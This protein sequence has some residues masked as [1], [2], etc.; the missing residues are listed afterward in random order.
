MKRFVDSTGRVFWKGESWRVELSSGGAVPLLQEP[1]KD[2]KRSAYVFDLD[3]TLFDNTARKHLVPR[4]DD[5]LT[6]GGWSK[7]NEHCHLDEIIEKSKSL[8]LS[9]YGMGHEILYVTSRCIDG[10]RE[11][12]AMLEEHN[13]PVEVDTLIMRGID[14]NRD[15]PEVKLDLFNS[16]RTEYHI[17]GAYDDDETVISTLISAG[18][19]MIKV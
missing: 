4:G 13:L 12:Y 14:D 11:T 17:I 9:L 15:A 8:A 10:F 6:T 16:L 19:N 1:D 18:Y 2:I 3:G 5:A 7:W